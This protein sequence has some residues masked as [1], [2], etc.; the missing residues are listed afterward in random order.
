MST[1]CNVALKLDDGSF[2]V[3]YGQ[4]DGYVEGVGTTLVLNYNTEEA[5]EKLIANGDFSVLGDDIYSTE[6]YHR[7]KGEPFDIS[8]SFKCKDQ[9]EVTEA[10]D[11]IEY[12]YVFEDGEWFYYNQGM[13]EGKVESAIAT[14]IEV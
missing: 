5:V 14:Q 13:F 11:N 3:I 12:F 4:W 10:A 6:F 2:E 1:K 9:I 7:D 8:K